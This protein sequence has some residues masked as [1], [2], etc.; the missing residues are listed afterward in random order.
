MVHGI[1]TKT[2]KIRSEKRISKRV[3]AALESDECRKVDAFLSCLYAIKMWII[4]NIFD[5]PSQKQPAPR[6]ESALT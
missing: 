1:I 5:F 3:L 4:N 6:A 2:L